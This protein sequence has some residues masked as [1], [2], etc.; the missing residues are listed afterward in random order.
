[1]YK[2]NKDACFY[3]ME[4]KFICDIYGKKYAYEYEQQVLELVKKLKEEVYFNIEDILFQDY[5]QDCFQSIICEFIKIGLVEEVELKSKPIE[6]LVCGNK[7]LYNLL[8]DN[9]TINFST[10]YIDEQNL[11]RLE[12]Y[13]ET[14]LF[15]TDDD[16]EK[17]EVYN[18]ILCKSSIS[19]LKVTF[20]KYNYKIGPFV[21]PGKNACIQCCNLQRKRVYNLMFDSSGEVRRFNQDK[22]L[23]INKEVLGYLLYECGCKINQIMENNE[24]LLQ[25]SNKIIIYSRSIKKDR[26]VEKYS[27]HFSCKDCGYEH[28]KDLYKKKKKE[29]PFSVERKIV[30]T[31]GGIRTKSDE[32]TNIL[33]KNALLKS[34]MKIVIQEEE[35]NPLF[36]ILP[37]YTA[38]ATSS[39]SSSIYTD[40]GRVYGKGITH[41]QAYYSACFEL[42]ERLS[43]MDYTS[44]EFTRHSYD[45]VREYVADVKDKINS[46]YGIGLTYDVFN[47][48]KK[49]DYVL[50]HSLI[51]KKDKLIPAS[52]VFLTNTIFEG[53]YINSGSSGLAAGGCIEDAIVQG[54]LEVIEHDA[55]ILGQCKKEKKQIVDYDKV[56]DYIIDNIEKIRERGYKIISRDYTNDIGIPV[57]VTWIWK[58]DRCI[59]Y[60]SR[61]W[62]CSI[63]PMIALERS[64]TEAIQGLSIFDNEE[65]CDYSKKNYTDVYANPFSI[66]NL[67][68]FNDKD[69]NFIGEKID[70]NIYEPH[71]NFSTIQEV[72]A[73]IQQ[74][75]V[76]TLG[77][78]DILY[79]DLT[80]EL[81]NIPVVKIIID[82]NVQEFGE[83]PII[84]TNRIKECVEYKSV[85][86]MY[87]KLYCGK[88]PH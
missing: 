43:A 85:A 17:E 73:Y 62:G 10:R 51:S 61:G 30:Y 65:I 34:D 3:I 44:K 46:I 60:A 2:F 29:L 67:S 59:D 14:V 23:H 81:F 64:I 13:S 35:D 1:M 5:D 47:K 54:L 22:S 21:M 11:K 15:I 88:F 25:F 52:L 84:T 45:G 49:T 42:I 69:I 68:Y 53:N 9:N 12:K 56:D 83:P 19:F 76:N 72:F 7:H 82:K 33:L 28:T 63:Y 48:Y 57:I 80:N 18:K 32:E 41:K 8:C 86:Q 78:I 79:I 75:I 4:D 66:F 26:V 24:L 74:K 55:M 36:D 20:S 87:G 77:Q 27:R 70:I 16:D 38:Y 71:V 37:T 50:G 31:E 39:I 40:M 6:I 58:D